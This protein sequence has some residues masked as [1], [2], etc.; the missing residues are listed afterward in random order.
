MPLSKYQLESPTLTEVTATTQ[1]PVM[2]G[3]LV[4]RETGKA[5]GGSV[6]ASMSSAQVPALRISLVRTV[7]SVRPPCDQMTRQSASISAA[8]PPEPSCCKCRQ[9]MRS[10]SSLRNSIE[11]VP[12]KTP[13]LNTGCIT[14]TAW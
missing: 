8:I 13:F 5:P 2:K 4:R 3:M 14:G 11:I 9:N 10:S 6:S 1:R 12:S 7:P